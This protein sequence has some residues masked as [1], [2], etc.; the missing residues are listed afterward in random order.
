MG[1]PLSIQI[2]IINRQSDIVLAVKRAICFDIL[3]NESASTDKLS[4]HQGP[5]LVAPHLVSVLGLSL[6]TF[7]LEFELCTL[8]AS[9]GPDLNENEATL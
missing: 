2:A 1:S 4:K 3:R 9:T 6:L 8:R 5:W 7:V